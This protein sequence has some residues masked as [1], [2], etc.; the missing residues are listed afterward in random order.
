MADVTKA[1]L[2][3]DAFTSIGVLAANE[4]PTADEAAYAERRYD[5]KLEEWRDMGLVYWPNTGRST[6]EIPMVV[7][8]VLTELLANEIMGAF[9]LQQTAEDKSAREALLLK[10]LRRIMAKKASGE[11]TRA[12]YF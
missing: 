12:D 2:Y 4:N 11:P 9:G 6:A 5:L 7:A 8:P 1:Q 3:T 10:R